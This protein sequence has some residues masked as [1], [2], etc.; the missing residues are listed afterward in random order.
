MIVDKNIYRF[1]TRYS[2]IVEV[3]I[4]HEYFNDKIPKSISVSPT[5][6]SAQQLR[7]Y[8]VLFKPSSNG[9][10]LLADA[11]SIS[12]SEVFS[13]PV[14]FKFSLDFRDPLFLNYTSLP[15][16]S[17]QHI[18]LNNLNTSKRLHRQTFVSEDDILES[19]Q[20]KISATIDLVLNQ[21][22]EF[23]GQERS[24]RVTE[25]YQIQFAA[26]RVLGRFNLYSSKEL[27]DFDRYFVTD[28][29]G[30][31][32]LDQFE[33][34]HLENGLKVF[35]LTIQDSL[36][37]AERFNHRY[38]LKRENEFNQI[39]SKYL[40]QLNAKNISFDKSLNEFIADVFVKID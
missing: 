36:K 13:G 8:G 18:Q 35:S 39:Y 38:F 26:R 31:L 29:T 3:N 12:S 37:I 14:T 30:D 25:V 16:H 27:Y 5:L 17:S 2:K 34:R 33:R 20:D 9:F 23:F 7:E 19:D 10:V 1:T 22:N 15:Y 24:D 28:E 6:T 32:R 21:N 40:P 11:D 4:Y